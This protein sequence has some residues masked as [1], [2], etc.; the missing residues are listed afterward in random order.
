[1][2]C[3]LFLSLQVI[4][5]DFPLQATSIDTNY[6]WSNST[7]AE[8]NYF[9]LRLPILKKTEYKTYFRVSLSGQTIDFFSKDN[10]SFNG[11]LT[12]HI[13]EY[14]D[15]ETK[16]GKGSERH[17]IVYQT[18]ELDSSLS[19]K[20]A[21]QIIQS[22]QATIPTDSLIKN[23]NNQYLHCKCV[24]FQF[25]IGND[26][27]ETSFSCPQNQSDS[28]DFKSIIL[29]NLELLEKELEL[30]IRYNEFTKLLPK[31]KTYSRDGYRLMYVMMNKEIEAFRKSK[32]QR[33]YF[34]SIK[35]SLDNYLEKELSKQE[36]SLDEMDCFEN[37]YVIFGIDGWLEKVNVS[38]PD[39]PKLRYGW[40]NYLADKQEVRKC[41]KKIKS[42]FRKIDLSVF[43]LKYKVRRTVSF[44]GDGEIEVRD[45]MLYETSK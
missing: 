15:I 45:D 16:W 32:P 43:N 44:G 36:I 38:K 42:I 26:Y 27:K 20:L 5:Q 31:G 35:D 13:I 29:S 33:D 9:Y 11:I 7:L 1:M 28:M 2:L 37:Y 41:R 12:N 4:A 18:Q 21:N 25:K 23:W 39:K 34:K 17:Q 10:I 24:D 22:G 19:T 14:K 40:G 30:E 6:T 8:R 3:F